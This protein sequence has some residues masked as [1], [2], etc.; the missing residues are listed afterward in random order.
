MDSTLLP[1]GYWVFAHLY[2]LNSQGST[3]AGF[4]NWGTELIILQCHPCPHCQTYPRPPLWQTQPGFE[5]MTLW[6]FVRHLNQLCHSGS[7]CDFAT[8]KWGK[9]INASKETSPKTHW[10]KKNMTLYASIKNTN[11]L[12][13]IHFCASYSHCLLNLVTI[14]LEVH[15]LS[16]LVMELGN[17]CKYLSFLW[18]QQSWLRIAFLIISDLITTVIT[19]KVA[20]PSSC[21]VECVYCF[22]WLDWVKLSWRRCVFICCVEVFL[23]NAT[24]ILYCH[25]ASSVDCVCATCIWMYHLVLSIA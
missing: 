9:K 11:K 23:G 25:G 2:H 16:H 20:L 10:Y 15:W 18:Q 24:F 12:E 13:K 5:P 21:V 22:N 6:S 1:P 7:L 19:I 17:H 14:V 8:K 4:G 3:Q